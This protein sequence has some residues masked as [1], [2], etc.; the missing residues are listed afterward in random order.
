[1]SEYTAL[2]SRIVAALGGRCI[3]CGFSDPRCLQIDHINGDGAEERRAH[4][5][6]SYL[7][8]ILADIESGRYQVLCANHQWIKRFDNMEDGR[9]FNLDAVYDLEAMT[10]GEDFQ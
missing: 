9:R 5:G 6:M 3:Y 2:R 4:G 8:N 1:M 10:L 7:T